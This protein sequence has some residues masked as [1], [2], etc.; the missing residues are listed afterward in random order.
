LQNWKLKKTEPS[1]LENEI[2]RLLEVMKNM[3]PADDE[4]YSDVADQLVKLYKLKEVDSKKRVSPDA[5]AA[6]ATN[7]AGILLILN[8]EHAHVMTSKALGFVV[9]SIK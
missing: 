8:F 1:S 6:A 4:K 5:M 9:K 3:D 2:E 7:L